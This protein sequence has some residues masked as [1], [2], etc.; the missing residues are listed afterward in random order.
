MG[1]LFKIFPAL[2]PFL[3]ILSICSFITLSSCKDDKVEELEVDPE[4]PMFGMKIDSSFFMFPIEGGSYEMTIS[5]RADWELIPSASEHLEWLSFS[6]SKGVAGQD[7]KVT[8]SVKPNDFRPRGSNVLLKMGTGQTYLHILQKGE[9]AGAELTTIHAVREQYQEELPFEQDQYIEGYVVMS[10]IYMNLPEMELFVMDQT[11]G[12]TLLVEDARFI[13]R[14]IP[15]GSKVR[16][17]LKDLYYKEVGG[18]MKLGYKKTLS[19]YE[20][21]VVDEKPEVTIEPREVT[22]AQVKDG[23]F[24]SEL[25]RIADMQ[26]EDTTATYGVSNRI[27]DKAGD[28]IALHTRKN[29]RFSN[30]RV[31]YGRGNFVGVV[32]AIEGNPLVMVRDT[33]EVASQMVDPRYITIRTFPSRA[34]F[35]TKAD[36]LNAL[37]RIPEG[38]DW[39][40]RIEK[41]CDWLDVVKNT[42][43]SS[44]DVIV[45]A[46]PDLKRTNNIIVSSG[47]VSRVF[48]VTQKGEQDIVYIYTPFE[49]TE[50][51]CTTNAQEPSEG[52]IKNLFD[53]K[54]DTFFHS[55]WSV[56]VN[57]THYLQIDFKRP[58]TL[59]KFETVNRH[60]NG[61]NSPKVVDIQ[62][63]NDKEGWTSVKQ[64]SEPGMTNVVGKEYASPVINFKSPHR[65][66]R[67]V[68]TSTHA[69]TKF[70]SLAEFRIYS[71]KIEVNEG[72]TE[73]SDK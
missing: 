61:R 40:V 63:S 16:I 35:D 31:P 10:P 70:F 55:S 18:L 19:T 5:M 14:R 47:E 9:I 67:Y 57:E 46:N 7:L 42:E 60:N 24:Q 64:L 66:M 30:R 65:Y 71:V 68:V 22:L 50:D 49:L 73:G 20:I 52:P 2:I 3:G 15:Q 29:S 72:P 17:F 34:A 23:L 56:T 4:N 38:N 45:K 8:V 33:L 39:E 6:P 26:F 11:G 69:G 12:I 25:V 27:I 58:L 21:D 28:F 1:R 51:N 13:N 43:T 54:N 53:G 37:L 59:I 36:T 44:F 32:T 48:T 41:E 62:V